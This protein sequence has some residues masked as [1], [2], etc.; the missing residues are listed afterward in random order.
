[1][2]EYMAAVIEKNEI[3]DTVEGN[4]VEEAAQNALYFFFKEQLE[5][6]RIVIHEMDNPDDECEPGEVVESFTI[7]SEFRK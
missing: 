2:S 4:S 6:A 3:V 7:T 5:E 1:M